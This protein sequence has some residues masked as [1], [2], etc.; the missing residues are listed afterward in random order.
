MSAYRPRKRLRRAPSLPVKL[1]TVICNF[2]SAAQTV[3]YG[4]LDLR[5][6]RN[7]ALWVLLVTRRAKRPGHRSYIGFPAPV[8]HF[9]SVP[10]VGYLNGRLCRRDLMI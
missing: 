5:I 1:L 7:D 4:D 9:V 2:L 6:V 8:S 3:L 10:M